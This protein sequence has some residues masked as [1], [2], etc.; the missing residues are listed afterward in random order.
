MLF[1][2]YIAMTTGKITGGEDM[3]E[4]VSLAPEEADSMSYVFHDN[5]LGEN[6]FLELFDTGTSEFLK[7]IGSIS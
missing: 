2:V 1:L 7:N 5:I 3:Q 6:P 4:N